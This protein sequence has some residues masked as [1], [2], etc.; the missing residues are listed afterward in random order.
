M[1]NARWNLETSE[2]ATTIFGLDLATRL[3]YTHVHLE[4]DLLLMIR[5]IA[6]RFFGLDNI[7][8]LS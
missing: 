1:V 5:S 8:Q 6:Q 3:G 7:L 4:G 2:A